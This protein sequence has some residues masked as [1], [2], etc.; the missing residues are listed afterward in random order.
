M[1]AAA[2]L[3]AMVQILAEGDPVTR[4]ELSVRAGLDRSTVGRY[5]KYWRRM[6]CVRVAEY[7]RRERH[8]VERLEWNFERKPDAPRPKP[9]SGAEKTRRYAERKRLKKLR[10]K[11]LYA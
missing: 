6:K 8:F 11:G 2:E 3:A 1:S 5:L 4:E 10:Q 7:Q 9:Y